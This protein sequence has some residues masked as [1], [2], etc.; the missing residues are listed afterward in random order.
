M[1]SAL[2]KRQGSDGSNENN[3]HPT[4]SGQ[5]NPPVVSLPKSL[6]GDRNPR[7]KLVTLKEKSIEKSVDSGNGPEIASTE[8]PTPKKV[9][10]KKEKS[11]DSLEP[12]RR[13]ISP[14][15]KKPRS[16]E[17]TPQPKTEKP[18]PEPHQMTAPLPKIKI[19]KPSTTTPEN[20]PREREFNTP[21]PTI[22]EAQIPPP[23]RDSRGRRMSPTLSKYSQIPVEI[24]DGAYTYQ[25]SGNVPQI[26]WDEFQKEIELER[27]RHL[28]NDSEYEAGFYDSNNYE[29]VAS[30]TKNNFEQANA[31]N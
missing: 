25:S 16:R 5:D 7:P 3:H 30:W 31:R 20:S 14:E 2:T 18:Q 28:E 8:E 15:R 11:R 6:L 9:A 13:S 4:S 21:E 22:P 19:Q 23:Q 1:P 17:P 24:I 26:D 29:Q 27:Q 12:S 10:H